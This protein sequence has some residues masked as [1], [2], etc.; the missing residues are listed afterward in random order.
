[1]KLVIFFLVCFVSCAFSQEKNDLQVLIFSA[2]DSTI[3]SEKKLDYASMDAQRLVRALTVA[4]KVDAQNITSL[5]NPSMEEF[6]KT[7]SALSKK[8]NQKFMFYF[9]GTRTKM[10][11]ICG[12]DL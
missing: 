2:E 1:M 12:T 4:G 8:K 9:Q 3:A 11:C 5:K 10:V 7:V 6:D